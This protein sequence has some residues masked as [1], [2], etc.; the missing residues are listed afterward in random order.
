MQVPASLRSLPNQL[1]LARIAAI[2]VICLL[3]VIGWD[4]LR[5]IALI[6]YVIA[7]ITD[8]FDGFLARRMGQSSDLGKMLDPIADK[9][10]VG[11]LLV[12]FAWTRDFSSLD[13]I[14]AI[15]ILL[16]EIFVAGLREYMG[17]RAISVPVTFLAKW[18]T[19]AQLVALFFVIVDGLLPSFGLISALL[20]WLAAALTVWTGWQYLMSVWPHFDS[21]PVE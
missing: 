15:A 10:L 1:T 4:W 17:G 7:A 12:T 3:L 20:L 5:W 6:L 8:W 13:L 9:L 16:R 21:P 18:K 2:P 11:A 19:T 14:P